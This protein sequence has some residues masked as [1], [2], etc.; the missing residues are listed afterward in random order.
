M[1]SFENGSRY[2]ESLIWLL[3]TSYDDNQYSPSK[4]II[5]SVMPKV[6]DAVGDTELYVLDSTLY[7]LKLTK[8]FAE[9]MDLFMDKVSLFER[10]LVVISYVN[11]LYI[12]RDK[13]LAAITNELS[14]WDTAYINYKGKSNVD[15]YF[16]YVIR[17]TELP[18]KLQK[19]LWQQK[20]L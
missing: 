19:V 17:D 14:C 8:G 4:F 20:D 11:D 7:N 15:G 12:E 6:L 16:N 18:H 2:Y 3:L 9:Y 13:Y 1:E 5:D 10:S